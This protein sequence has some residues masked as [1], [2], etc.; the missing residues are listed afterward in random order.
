MVRK[1]FVSF[2]S[3]NMTGAL[4]RISHQALAMERFDVILPFE[5]D[6]LDS[7]FVSTFK[8]KLQEDVRGYG[9]WVWKAQ[10]IKQALEKMD[11]GDMLLYADAGCHLN[12]EG[13]LRL[14]QYF[15]M[16][17]PDR[18]LVVFQQ[19][20]QDTVFCENSPGIPS[21][22]NRDWTKGD[23]IDYFDVRGRDD[24]LSS[25]T[26]YATTFFMQK[27]SITSKLVD[28]WQEPARK[29]WN[30]IDDS[31][32]VSPNFPGFIEH[33]HDQSIFSILCNFYP[34]NV[35]SACEIVYPKIHGRGGD[36]K[37]LHDFPIHARRDRRNNL[38]S[39]L[40]G[41]RIDA[42]HHLRRLLKI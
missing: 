5:K 11:E 16:L 36:W 38:S 27:N 6:G 13:R 8:D 34:V 26:Y 32:T 20:P 19:D 33:R 10:V 31:P 42:S 14:D 4:R 24:I 25:E 15:E 41:V 2:A 18:P 35:I 7:R 28:D 17:V 39:R 22:P 23:L 21:W 9:Y 29:N 1:F 3:P 37:R 30:L 40:K 12:R